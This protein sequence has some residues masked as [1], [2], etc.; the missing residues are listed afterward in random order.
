MSSRPSPVARHR[1]ITSEQSQI[2]RSSPAKL[3]H[4]AFSKMT[5]QDIHS[6][7]ANT[8]IC[9]LYNILECANISV[10]VALPN[11]IPSD[12]RLAH[13]LILQ[14]GSSLPILEADNVTAV[15][16]LSSIEGGKNTW[17]IFFLSFLFQFAVVT[18]FRA[19]VTT[20][21]TY[22]PNETLNMQSAPYRVFMFIQCP[23]I[24]QHPRMEYRRKRL[25]VGRQQHIEVVS[26]LPF[27]TTASAR[28][29]V[30]QCACWMRTPPHHKR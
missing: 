18:H 9:A 19:L 13:G 28:E 5:G 15:A 10:G 27:R 6:K 25:A 29:S 20:T 4:K 17:V 14:R 23:K 24:Q 16:S 8:N 21:L 1:T 7:V 11:S 22:R 30:L 26:D 3:R 2:A 12:S